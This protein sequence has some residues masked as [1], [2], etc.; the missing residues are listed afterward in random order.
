MKEGA[1][2][3]NND[4]IADEQEQP[5]L[6]VVEGSEDT[7]EL[8]DKQDHP[9]L[10][11]IDGEQPLVE[12]LAIDDQ[13]DLKVID[14]D[15]KLAVDL[16]NENNSEAVETE[17][18]PE[19]AKAQEHLEQLSDPE[20]MEAELNKEIE[21]ANTRFAF[22]NARL[23]AMTDVGVVAGVEVG[24]QAV[25]QEMADGAREMMEE[26]R[27]NLD[28]MRNLDVKALAKESAGKVKEYLKENWVLGTP[29]VTIPLMSIASG[30]NMELAA[31]AALQLAGGAIGLDIA[32]DFVQKNAEDVIPPQYMIALIAATT[33]IAEAGSS[34]AAAVMGDNI[35]DV[36]ATPLGSCTSNI[37]I[38]GLAVLWASKDRA[39]KD[40]VIEPGQKM[41]LK[42]FK[43][44]IKGM[45]RKVIAKQVGM[46]GLIAIDAAIFQFFV[47][48]EIKKGNVIPLIGWAAANAPFLIKY[49]KKTVFSKG[50]QFENAIGDMGESQIEDFRKQMSEAEEE[51]G[52]GDGNSPIEQ[53]VKGMGD[54]KDTEDKDD[55]KEI[56]GSIEE[57]VAELK[58][59]FIDDPAFQEKFEEVLAQ[60]PMKDVRNL[61]KQFGFKFEDK[62]DKKKIAAMVAGMAAVVGLSVNLEHGVQN[63]SEA[64]PFIDKGAAGYFIHSIFTSMGELVTSRRFFKD[65]ND[66]AAMQN[67]THSNAINIGLAKAAM[68][69]SVARSLILGR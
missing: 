47:R 45:D 32:L 39:E 43:Q 36:G 62:K 18:S 2:N 16:S 23:L 12:E 7:E 66:K 22:D 11:V 28:K 4:L 49:F 50:A 44:M 56:R 1:E 63:M 68:V 19:F 9:D 33:N 17:G 51:M 38:A 8:I 10:T 67:I 37:G 26:L 24:G 52:D 55:Q 6:P 21:A 34:Q 60:A 61:M 54:F 27:A 64:L 46:S 53:I 35:G 42:E 29:L 15:K 59:R 13:P 69:T 58:E 5:D 65:S 41:G 57:R 48:P 14:G 20:V 31:T 30:G 25:T 3:L 40:G